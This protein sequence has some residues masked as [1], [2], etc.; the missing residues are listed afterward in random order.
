MLKTLIPFVQS[1]YQNW[2]DLGRLGGLDKG[3]YGIN[4]NYVI[5]DYYSSHK[6]IKG[7][8]YIERIINYWIKTE[9][10]EEILDTLFL[11]YSYGV[12]YIGMFE[13]KIAALKALADSLL[14]NLKDR[15]NNCF[16]LHFE[17]FKFKIAYLKMKDSTLELGIKLIDLINKSN[18]DLQWLL[19]MKLVIFSCTFD[20]EVLIKIEKDFQSIISWLEEDFQCQI[21]YINIGLFSYSLQ[22]LNNLGITIDTNIHIKILSIIKDQK[23]TFVAFIAI[24]KTSKC[25]VDR[26][27][28][29]TVLE[30]LDNLGVSKL[31][32][33][34]LL[35][36]FFLISSNIC[37]PDDLKIDEWYK[38]L[39]EF[40]DYLSANK[41]KF[42]YIEE[43]LLRLYIPFLRESQGRLNIDSY[44][45]YAEDFIELGI[46]NDEGRKEIICEIM[47]SSIVLYLNNNQVEKVSIILFLLEFLVNYWVYKLRFI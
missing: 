28:L 32:E 44:F 14:E 47:E 12:K 4:K 26:E 29:I 3:F 1:P 21:Y 15:E 16:Y 37:P 42:D 31:N 36:R 5:V 34:R 43:I 7:L 40:I 27:H 11:I 38:E 22:A 35:I 19:I 2:T 8:P 24:I 18:I 17:L 25:L 46:K 13:T 33:L 9:N 39:Q 20:K 45:K 10:I 6:K 41:D 30:Y 23:E